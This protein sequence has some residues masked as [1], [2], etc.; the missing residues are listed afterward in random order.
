MKLESF[1][2]KWAAKYFIKKK[3][4]AF[5]ED[6]KKSVN[7]VN[8]IFTP[9]SNFKLT[10]S[11]DNFDK[12][13]LYQ[14]SNY[15]KANYANAI[16]KILMAPNIKRIIIAYRNGDTF[17]VLKEEFNIFTHT[18]KVNTLIYELEVN[19]NDS[20]PVF[21]RAIYVFLIPRST[22]T[23]TYKHI[24]FFE[25]SSVMKL[26]NAS[27]QSIVVQL[28]GENSQ[29]QLPKFIKKSSP[30][31]MNKYEKLEY[32]KLLFTLYERDD[33]ELEVK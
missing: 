2:I 11:R 27:N 6:N 30:N 19:I 1:P 26:I 25:F 8:I 12:G 29:S 7:N 9:Q 24:E 13:S 17:T 33:I 18:S 10:A 5:F 23:P 32:Q 20:E 21:R 14:S 28:F 3:Y 4:N 16:V 31:K 22:D 15:A